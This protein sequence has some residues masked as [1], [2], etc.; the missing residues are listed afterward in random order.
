VHRVRPGVSVKLSTRR[1]SPAGADRR[2][3]SLEGQ[4]IANLESLELREFCTDPMPRL[5]VH[6]VGDVVQYTLPDEGFGPNS[7]VDVV[8]AEANISELKR[9]IRPEPGKER[10]G[11][12]FAEVVPPARI[13]QF[14]CLVHE[15]LYPGPEPGL[16]I[17][18]T[19]FEG[20]ASAND[21][22][23]DIDRFD[24]LEGIEPLGMGLS[25][26][27]S[28]H[29]PRYQEL[30]RHVFERTGFQAPRFRGY[31]CRI[32]YPVYGSQVVMLFRP[33]TEP[34]AK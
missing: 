14:D 18:D 5:K 19:S 20:V 29:V 9:Y 30:I 13:L 26:F 27:R 6:Q 15:D 4:P 23:R 1:M 7:A 8:F 17:Y 28:P 22:S 33:E 21:P 2:P 25:R 16:R 31:R 34:E 24:L 10:S 12:F 11:Y 3:V 32:D